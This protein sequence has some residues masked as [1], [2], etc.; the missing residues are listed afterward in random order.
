MERAATGQLPLIGPQKAYRHDAKAWL[1]QLDTNLNRG[2]WH[3]PQ[4]ARTRFDTW[5]DQY[6]AAA[7]HLRPTTRAAINYSLR[8]H[9]RPSFGNM[10]LGSITPLHVRA[11]VAD[12]TNRYQ[13]VTVRSVYGH[14]R[15]ILNAAVAA[16]MIAISPCR[17]IKLPPK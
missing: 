3:D 15:S 5:A 12:L 13:P 2:L 1:A 11:L 8:R 14:L 17:G 16:D 9:L 10:P 6:L 7:V 4:L